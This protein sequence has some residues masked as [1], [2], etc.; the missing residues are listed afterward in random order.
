MIKTKVMTP[1]GF[2]FSRLCNLLVKHTTHK[3]SVALKRKMSE[4]TSPLL[5]WPDLFLSLC[6]FYPSHHCY[7][8]HH[9]VLFYFFFGGGAELIPH[10]NA[11][12]CVSESHTVAW[13]ISFAIRFWHKLKTGTVGLCGKEK[14]FQEKVHRSLCKSNVVIIET[15]YWSLKK[16]SELTLSKQKYISAKIL[17]TWTK[18]LMPTS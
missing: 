2:L 15:F 10:S 1:W 4:S 8:K 13:L 9:M 7:T 17:M 18:N 3:K 5:L 14:R 12:I 16:H 11:S 6:H